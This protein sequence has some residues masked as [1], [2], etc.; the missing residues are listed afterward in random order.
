MTQKILTLFDEEI[1]TASTHL[2]A[3]KSAR[4]LITMK[5]GP[6]FLVSEAVSVTKGKRGPG[7]PKGKRGP[8]RP[9]GSRNKIAA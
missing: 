2:T 4:A 6:R 5:G 8:G 3:L 7:R 9:K 1:A